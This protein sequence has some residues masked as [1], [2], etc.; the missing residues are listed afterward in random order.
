MFTLVDLVP[1][2]VWCLLIWLIPTTLSWLFQVFTIAVGTVGGI[3]LYQVVQ[4]YLGL[5]A[6]GGFGLSGALTSLMQAMKDEVKSADPEGSKDLNDTLSE[7]AN[8]AGKIFGMDNIEQTRTLNGSSVSANDIKDVY[9]SL[10]AD[11][12]GIITGLLTVGKDIL[13]QEAA[14]SG[15][16]NESTKSKGKEEKLDEP[17]VEEIHDESNL[18]ELPPAKDLS[19]ALTDLLSAGIDSSVQGISQPN[20]D[21]TNPSDEDDIIASLRDESNKKPSVPNAAEFIG[22][23]IEGF[24]GGL[25]SPTAMTELRGGVSPQMKAAT[26]TVRG[27]AGALNAVTD[28]HLNKHEVANGTIGAPDSLTQATC[29]AVKPS[30]EVIEQTPISNEDDII[31]SLRDE[32]NQKPPS[33][34]IMGIIDNLAGNFLPPNLL[35]EYQRDRDNMSAERVEKINTNGLNSTFDLMGAVMSIAQD[36]VEVDIQTTNPES[37]VEKAKTLES[38]VQSKLNSA[39]S[40]Y[41]EATDSNISVGISV[42]DPKTFLDTVDSVKEKVEILQAT[43]QSNFIDL[44]RANVSPELDSKLVEL[45]TKY[46]QRDADLTDNQCDARDL[47]IAVDS[48]CGFV[49]GVVKKV[50]S[51]TDSSVAEIFVG[52]LVDATEK[53]YQEQIV[54]SVVDE[55]E[56]DVSVENNV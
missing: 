29:G 8:T 24:L 22:G 4:S 16:P 48:A 46:K 5:K 14:K 39:F 32:S 23:F 51:R 44:V 21:E 52:S 56:N 18:D 55:N 2:P 45:R 6:L 10:P 38:Q 7:L 41:N 26:D 3:A 11:F 36:V 15:S 53:K 17:L 19:G 37:T 28:T 9:N 43:D 33:P 13:M 49:K 25:L 42:S 12:P 1:D 34:T 47:E 27:A 20:K 54:Q 40:A 50:T 35:A 31:A 30:P